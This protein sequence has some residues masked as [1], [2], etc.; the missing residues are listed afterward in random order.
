MDNDVNSLFSTIKK[1]LTNYINTKLKILHLEILEKTSITASVLLFG[2]IAL[3]LAF[4]VVLFIF[5][6]LAFCIG[7]VLK[8]IA[9]GLAIV[10]FIYLI[11]LGIFLMKRTKIQS[12][13]VNAFLKELKKSEKEENVKDENE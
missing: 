8:S 11:L 3:F 10:A 6:A 13:I 4:F 12:L 2:V 9:A 1:D 7:E 5:F